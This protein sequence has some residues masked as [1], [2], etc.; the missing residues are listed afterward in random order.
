MRS[1]QFPV[2]FL[3]YSVRVKTLTSSSLSGTK[4]TIRGGSFPSGLRI[5]VAL[6]LIISLASAIPAAH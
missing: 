1:Q 4:G 2:Q 6:L 3:L 5:R